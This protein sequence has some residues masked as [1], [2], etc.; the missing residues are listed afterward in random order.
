MRICSG[1]S[2]LRRRP[3]GERGV[4]LVLTLF[5]LF[6]TIAMMTQLSIGSSVAWNATKYRTDKLRMEMASRSAGQEILQLLLD[7]VAGADAASGFGDAMS[8]SADP[9]GA[10]EGE[11]G[12]EEEDSPSD[13]GEDA[14]AKPMR[15][16]IGDIEITTFVQDE[17]GKY[18]VHRIVEGD[19]DQ[20]Q[21]ERER[22]ARILDSMRDGMDGDLDLIEGRRIVEELVDY[23]NRRRRDNDLP[24]AD[25]QSLEDE[26]DYVLLDVLEEM[27]ILNTVDESIFFDLLLSDEMVAPGLESVLTC[28]TR[29]GFEEADSGGE[30]GDGAAAPPVA[31]DGEEEPQS[32][33]EGGLEGVLTADPAI[34][35]LVNL[36]TAPRAVLEGMFPG[37]DLSP[38]MVEDLV[39]WRNEVDEEAQR[40]SDEQEVDQEAQDL[41]DA[42]FGVD[43][44]QPKQFFTSLEDVSKVP[45]FEADMM[46]E[47]T[48]ALLQENFG[49][50]SDVFSV[51]LWARVR[52]DDG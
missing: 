38:V 40:E 21:E 9:M 18:N 24:L 12:E 41:Q 45:G 42:L 26:D 7:D 5:V 22:M 16:P 27:L 44:D 15:I 2:R 10:A 33:G 28:Y 14:W 11:E 36:N 23:M 35:D 34:G 19:D 52:R 20:Q 51:Y 1:S 25:R 4:V 32:F 3:G 13:S 6:I 29:P 39:R 49:V 30:L 17:N 47:E 8:A 37:Y 46:S 48:Q 43:K 50:Q 31:G